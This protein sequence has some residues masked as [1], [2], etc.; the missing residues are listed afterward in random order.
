MCIVRGHT[1]ALVTDHNFLDRLGR[2]TEGEKQSFL[3]RENRNIHLIQLIMSI[4]VIV[5]YIP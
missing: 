1:M 5:H 4:L 3:H 2:V